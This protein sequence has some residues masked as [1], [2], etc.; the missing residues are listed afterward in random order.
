MFEWNA[1]DEKLSILGRPLKK[2]FT[3]REAHSFD[4]SVI[5]GNRNNMDSKKSHYL[6]VVEKQITSHNYA[7]TFKLRFDNFDFSWVVYEMARTYFMSHEDY[8]IVSE[9]MPNNYAEFKKKVDNGAPV[10]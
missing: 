7:D 9:Y 2:L 3:G 6:Q 10:R 4:R 1:F 8:D 5:D